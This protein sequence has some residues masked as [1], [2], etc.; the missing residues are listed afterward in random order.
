MF[1]LLVV[2]SSDYFKMHAWSTSML[3][4][5][6]SAFMLSMVKMLLKGEAGGR[7]L[8][9]HGNNIVDHIMENS[10]NCVFEFLS[11]PCLWCERSTVWVFIDISSHYL[12][13]TLCRE[14]ITLFKYVA[15]GTQGNDICSI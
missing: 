14:H 8:N 12:G 3:L 6:H 13:S 7:A 4:L 15:F 9:S 1:R 2:S 11:E 5:L 10:W